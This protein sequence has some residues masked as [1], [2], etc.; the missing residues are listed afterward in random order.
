MFLFFVNN[1]NYLL[2]IYDKAAGAQ[3]SS[4]LYVGFICLICY[5]LRARHIHTYIHTYAAAL[6]IK[7]LYVRR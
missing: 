6:V 5:L 1:I 7:K 2:I 3:R 4:R